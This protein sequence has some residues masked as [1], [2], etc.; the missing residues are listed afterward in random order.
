L[1]AIWNPATQGVSYYE[2][3]V[4]D[5]YTKVNSMTGGWRKIGNS[6]KGN[7]V[8]IALSPGRTTRLTS[9][10]DVNTSSFTVLSTEGFA[11]EDI[12]YVGNEI[13]SVYKINSNSFGIIE[14]GIQGSFKTL[15]TPWGEAVS[16]TGYVVSVR[17]VMSDGTYVPSEKGTPIL[18]YRID[19]T[20]PTTPGSPDPQVSEGSAAGNSYTLKWTAS[21]DDE[22]NIMSY[23]IQERDGINPVWHTINAIPGYKAGGSL[24]NVYIVGDPSTPGETPR[25]SGKYYS[26]RVRAWNFAGLASEW[27]PVSK[28]AATSIGKEVIQEYTSYPNPVDLR[29]GGKEGK[30]TISYTLNDD[31]EVT[32]T[33][34]D[35]LGYVVKEFSFSRGS[36][37]GK[38]GPNLLE[39]DGK[40]GLGSTV[41]K[42]GYLVRIKASSPRGS[43]TVVRKI[44]I[45]H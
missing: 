2:L 28:A 3:A 25:Q 9:R 23:E 29:K 5:N 39:W 17:G 40:N 4:G 34:Y 30:V 10:I 21:K 15:H 44:G 6:L 42:G 11:D 41:S 27:S 36:P 31:A 14:R 43:K 18:I 26:Y 13:M 38:M 24:N 20:K 12:L 35:L 19:T 7:I 37:G 16:N 45:I 33:I 1:K 8:D 22:S 32:I